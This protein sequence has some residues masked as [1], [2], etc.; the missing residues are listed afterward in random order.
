MRPDFQ[1]RLVLEHGD[2]RE[3]SGSF[4]ADRPIDEGDDL[5]YERRLW[6]VTQKTKERDH[7]DGS[8][9]EQLVCHP[10]PMTYFVVE[11]EDGTRRLL[12]EYETRE[13]AE[14]A[15]AEML[16]RIEREEGRKARDAASDVRYIWHA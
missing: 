8:E 2:G 14:A 11:R 6:R 5:T 15:L 9:F 10:A 16:D 4:H 13:Q 1:Y 7:R 12:G 3:E